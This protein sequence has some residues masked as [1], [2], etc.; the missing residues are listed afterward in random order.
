M[1]LQCR[2]EQGD[3]PS[4]EEYYSLFPEKTP[5]IQSIFES[6]GPGSER[7]TSALSNGRPKPKTLNQESKFQST[8]FFDDS[9]GTPRRPAGLVKEARGEYGAARA[10]GAE[11]NTP[12]RTE[13]PPDSNGHGFPVIPG[14]L[15]LGELGR[16]GMGIVYKAR[17]CRLQRVV[18]LKMILPERSYSHGK[19]KRFLAEAAVVA[20][21][22]HP[23]LVQIFSIGEHKG[24]C[25]FSLELLEGGNLN[26][27][28]AGTPQP[29]AA[30]AFLIETLARALDYAHAKGVV[31]RD[32]KPANILLAADGTPKVADFGLAKQVDQDVNMTEDGGIVGTPSYMAPEQAWGKNTEVGPKADIYALGVIF[33]EM[34]VG[35]PPL[36]GAD[37]W[38]TVK[39]VR[40]QEP[41]APRSLVPQVPRDLELLCLKCL[42]KEPRHRFATA[43]ALADELARFR[44]GRPIQTRPTPLWE[45]GWKWARRQ[46]ALASLIMVMAV[47]LLSAVLYL[48]ERVALAQRELREQQRIGRLR[49]ISQTLH[50]QAQQ[51][52]D[53]NQTKE[54]QS[55]LQE[56]YGIIQSEPSLN[57]LA[58]RNGELRTEVAAQEAES[59]RREADLHEARD[60]AAT[61]RKFLELRNDALF[62]GMVFTGVDIL[63]N[64][65]ATKAACES[66]LALFAVTPEPSVG[67]V[68]SRH[69]SAEQKEQANAL[70]Y[71]L[72]LV[73]ADAEA[74]PEPGMPKPGTRQ[75]EKALALLQCAARLDLPTQQAYHMRRADYLELLGDVEAI[76]N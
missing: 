74:Q 37:K 23:N 59:A 29:A 30:T 25:Y 34:L 60:V 10:E 64:V 39:L 24:H 2:R 47:A 55:H 71:E 14:Y 69:L 66:A 53:R 51:A 50:V 70:C 7:P 48:V 26:Q 6:A 38:E 17:D 44:E 27:K 46:P 22:Q 32:L 4:P 15:I 54:A 31:H 43:G 45:K 18:A 8:I 13:E 28:L 3:Q 67:P 21:F 57:D 73:W 35:R 20:R 33:Y 1:E 19:L 68:F 62:H 52:R 16:G 9:S 41:V 40:T 61:Y 11:A 58:A 56:A 12:D 76:R 42:E 5:L 65:A 49:D 75:L 63:L 36:K 72:L